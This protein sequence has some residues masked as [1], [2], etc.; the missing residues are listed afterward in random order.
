MRQKSAR[1]RT[2]QKS[3]GFFLLYFALGN[4]RTLKKVADYCRKIGVGISLKTLELWSRRFN[5]Q[6]KIAI[7]EARRTNERQ[8][9]QKYAIEEMNKVQAQVGRAILMVAQRHAEIIRELLDRDPDKPLLAAADI[10]R[11]AREG[12]T[13]E[14]LA[15]G[16]VTSRNEEIKAEINSLIIQVCNIF[17]AVNPLTDEDARKRKFAVLFNRAIEGQVKLIEGGNGGKK[18]GRAGNLAV[19]NVLRINP[20][21]SP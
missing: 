3:E 17:M 21:P 10:P 4:E 15:R 9:V 19:T 7:L 20:K 12:A 6:S 14:R 11:F 16:E 8:M 1:S 18:D 13:L 5:W 2:E